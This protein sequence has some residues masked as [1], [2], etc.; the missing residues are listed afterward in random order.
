MRY[1]TILLALLVPAGAVPAADKDLASEDIILDLIDKNAENSYSATRSW[2]ERSA[3]PSPSKVWIHIRTDTQVNDADKIA[4]LLSGGV[5]LGPVT[6]DVDLK[7]VQ[8]VEIGPDGAAQV[9]YFKREDQAT[10]NEIARTLTQ[11]GLP[12]HPESFVEE[13]RDATYIDVGHIEIWLPE[14]TGSAFLK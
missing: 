10:A 6:R 4:T 11:A 5:H 8:R 14:S 2:T 9:R 1:L 7:P 12:T 3:L 13:F